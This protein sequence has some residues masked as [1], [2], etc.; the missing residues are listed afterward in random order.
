MRREGGQLVQVAMDRQTVETLNSICQ[1]EGLTKSAAIEKALIA[2]RKQVINALSQDT[3]PEMAAWLKLSELFATVRPD[4]PDNVRSEL[5]LRA[6]RMHDTPDPAVLGAIVEND[7]PLPVRA[8]FQYRQPD[9]T[10]WIVIDW[11]TNSTDRAQQAMNV[12][13]RHGWS[14]EEDGPQER[15]WR[16]EQKLFRP[17]KGEHGAWTVDEHKMLLALAR[18]ALRKVGF[19]K[20]PKT[21]VALADS[22]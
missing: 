7:A 20:V 22:L 11:N 3:S 5:L 9:S 8:T 19:A 18:R 17:G 16:L 10:H 14:P 2:Y 12:L 1:A 4:L 6:R 13:A 15:G 21:Q